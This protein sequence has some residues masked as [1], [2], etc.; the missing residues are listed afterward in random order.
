[1]ESLGEATAVMAVSDTM[2]MAIM[3][4][5]LRIGLSVPGDLSVIGFDDVAMAEPVG[6]TTV[7]QPTALKG[8]IAAQLLVDAIGGKPSASQQLPVELV[9]RSS[10]APPA[11]R[12]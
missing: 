6:L 5:A 12:S 3:D 7:R 11:R 4:R 9:V 1:M 8:R 10:T 2:A